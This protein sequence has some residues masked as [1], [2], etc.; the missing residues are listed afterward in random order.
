MTTIAVPK[1]AVTLKAYGFELHLWK[2]DREREWGATLSDSNQVVTCKFEEDNLM[3]AKL[4]LLG[5]ARNRAI[6]RSN[7]A[8]LPG[9]NAFLNSWKPTR[10]TK[11]QYQPE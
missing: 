1:V 2:E 9:C 4:Y 10:L 11:A 6:Q 8:D 3:L 5:E 7:A